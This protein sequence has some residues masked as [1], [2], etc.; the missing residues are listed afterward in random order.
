MGAGAWSRWARW[1]QGSLPTEWA[2]WV[3]GSGCRG[4]CEQIQLPGWAYGPGCRGAGA[5]GVV[6]WVVEVSEEHHTW[7]RQVTPALH[8]HQKGFQC[9]GFRVQA[10]GFRVQGCRVQYGGMQVCRVQLTGPRCW[11]IT[12]GATRC[13]K[14]QNTAS[15]VW[16]FKI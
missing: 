14:S 4:E 12:Q 15:Y 16:G 7:Y 5:K 3:Q 11:R 1:V 9:S 6:D 8:E 10:L 13:G 2:R